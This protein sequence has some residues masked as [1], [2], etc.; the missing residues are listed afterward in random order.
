MN[1]LKGIGATKQAQLKLDSTASGKEPSD[2]LVN[3]R[4]FELARVFFSFGSL[5]LSRKVLD[6]FLGLRDVKQ[7]LPEAVKQTRQEAADAKTARQMLATGKLFFNSLMKAS[8]RRTDDDMNAFWAAAVA[9]IPRDVF[10][11]RQGRAVARLLGIPYRTVKRA[12]GSVM[13]GQL[14]DASG[15]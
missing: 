12:S 1:R 6:K 15:S 13:R 2:S 3:L 4:A 9:Y 11:S 14:E 5:E 8:G 10:E 7:L